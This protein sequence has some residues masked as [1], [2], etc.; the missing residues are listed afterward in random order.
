MEAWEYPLAWA[1]YVIAGIGLG[2]LLRLAFAKLGWTTRAWLMGS[3]LV[4]AFTPWTLAGYPDHMAPAVLVLVMDILLKGGGNTLEGGLVLVITYGVMLLSVML[5][6]VR[7]SKQ[8]AA[9]SS[10]KDHPDTE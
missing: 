9:E 1:A 4:L 6:S 7:R 10:E 2:G 8:K 3:Y 5:M